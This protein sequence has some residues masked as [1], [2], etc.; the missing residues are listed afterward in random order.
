MHVY[1]NAGRTDPLKDSRMPP[2]FFIPAALLRREWRRVADCLPRIGEAILYRTESYQAMGTYEGG[3]IWRCS[4]GER[5][6]L[7]ILWWQPLYD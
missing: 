7:S 3:Q 4:N 1:L 5:E 2:L 6:I